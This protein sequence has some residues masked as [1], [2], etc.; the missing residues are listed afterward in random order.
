MSDADP[1]PRSEPRTFEARRI[2]EMLS[3]QTWAGVE[4]RTADA[5][6]ELAEAFV[7]MI[8]ALARAGAQ[9]ELLAD[10]LAGIEQ[11]GDGVFFPMSGK[12]RRQ[13]PKPLGGGIEGDAA[14]ELVVSAWHPSSLQACL[15]RA[16]FRKV[17]AVI[18]LSPFADRGPTV[19]AP[20]ERMPIADASIDR[21][22]FRQGI[23]T[24]L[25]PMTVLAECHRILIPGGTLSL[26]APFLETEAKNPDDGLRFTA[27]F[28]S[29]A[30][31]EAGF[32]E[33]AIR[34]SDTL[35]TLHD[36]AAQLRPR[37]GLDKPDARRTELVQRLV[38]VLLA[39]LSGLDDRFAAAPGLYRWIDVVAT[40]PGDGTALGARPKMSASATAAENLR[41]LAKLLRCPQTGAELRAEGDDVLAGG[42]EGP[43]YRIEG[44]TIRLDRPID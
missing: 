23:E 13:G 40:K 4:P 36:L 35:T 19:A 43:R 8:E 33:I 12:E 17:G 21:I 24:S 26:R 32:A 3:A 31:P 10:V 9:P 29:R 39:S 14:T 5:W 16:L 38:A 20:L 15:E 28:F 2:L 34:R 30:M 27:S 25:H 42:P 6:L 11:F 7:A 37:K 22:V 18:S 44:G 1:P 41:E